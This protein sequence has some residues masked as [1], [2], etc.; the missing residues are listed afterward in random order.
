M[1]NMISQLVYQRLQKF[2]L[3]LSHSRSIKLI[4]HLG[5][6]FDVIVKKEKAEEKVRS[7]KVSKNK[8]NFGCK[9]LLW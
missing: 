1:F 3:C 4:S 6:D 7:A 9:Y 2:G 5:N 8:L